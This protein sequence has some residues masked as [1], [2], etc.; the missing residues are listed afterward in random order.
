MKSK[1]YRFQI[2]EL[3]KTYKQKIREQ[4]LKDDQD[5][6]TANKA[7]YETV[8]FEIE[9][10]DKYLDS[11]K[12]SHNKEFFLNLDV[13]LS[14]L[15]KEHGIVNGFLLC[16]SDAPTASVYVNHFEQGAMTDLSKALKKR[17]SS[18]LRTRLCFGKKAKQETADG[19]DSV[20]MA[21]AAKATA[22]GRS[23]LVLIIDGKLHLGKFDDVVYAEF[24]Y[25]PDHSFTVALFGEEDDI[26]TANL[27]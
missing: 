24:D 27:V 20:N 13:L 19:A 5:M 26:V 11:K 7:L 18:G 21:A 10:G 15:I 3:I 6:D 8:L 16:S 9:S 22:I 1:Y 4:K 14:N 23:A 2:D 25:K 12:H 17:Y